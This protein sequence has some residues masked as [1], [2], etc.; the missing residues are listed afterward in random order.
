MTWVASLR[1]HQVS[2]LNRGRLWSLRRGDYV[3]LLADDYEKMGKD[4]TLTESDWHNLTWMAKQS[5]PMSIAYVEWLQSLSSCKLNDSG[6]GIRTLIFLLPRL[7]QEHTFSTAA[8]TV[9]FTLSKPVFKRSHKTIIKWDFRPI[10]V[11]SGSAKVTVASIIPRHDTTF[12]GS[13][14]VP[15]YHLSLA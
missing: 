1:I 8:F 11:G 2:S 4:R 12:S 15:S 13:A 14:C 6:H 10:L 7:N 3:Y 5:I 9:L